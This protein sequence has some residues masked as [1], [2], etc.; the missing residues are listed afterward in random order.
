MRDDKLQ[1]SK[2]TGKDYF[3]AT[4]FNSSAGWQYEHVNTGDKFWDDARPDTEEIIE[5][6]GKKWLKYKQKEPPTHQT[7]L[8]QFFSK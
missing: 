7:T 2:Q 6:C 4:G 8:D 3:I 5:N 1:E